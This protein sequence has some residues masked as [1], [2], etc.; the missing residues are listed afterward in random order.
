MIAKAGMKPFKKEE[1]R[2][3]AEYFDE[4]LNAG[5]AM[6]KRTELE[7]IHAA[8]KSGAKDPVSV[9]ADIEKLADGPLTW[10]WKSSDDPTVTFNEDDEYDKEEADYEHEHANDI[11]EEAVADAASGSDVKAPFEAAGQALASA[12]GSASGPR[13][14]ATASGSAA[15]SAS[16]SATG[17]ASK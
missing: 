12:E 4:L 3:I 11:D 10:L 1:G 17:T 13:P 7:S 14:M 8:F 2:G 16:G 6:R 5:R 9:I 15:G